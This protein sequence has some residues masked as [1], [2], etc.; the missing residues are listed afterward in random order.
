MKEAV[1]W[2]LFKSEAIRTVGLENHPNAEA[3]YAW[4]W[5][6]FGEYGKEEVFIALCDLAEMQRE[7]TNETQ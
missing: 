4:C 5:E 6:N 2:E 1:D 7:A 3:M